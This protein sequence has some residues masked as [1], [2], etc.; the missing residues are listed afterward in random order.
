MPSPEARQFRR[1]LLIV[2]AV[3]LGIVSLRSNH[4][5]PPAS[6]AQD[7]PKQA[8]SKATAE[9]QTDKQ[10]DAPK[11]EVDQWVDLF[12]GK[13]LNGW[14][15]TNFGGEGEVEVDKKKK[16]LIL[17]WGMD[18][19][20]IT[21]RLKVPRNNYEIELECQRV[22]GN[23]FFCGLT[24]PINDSCA[25]LIVGGWGGGVCGISC[26]DRLDA[27]ENETTTYRGFET[28]KWYPVKV[29]VA[30][31]RLEAWVEGKKIVDVSTKKRE[32]YVRAEMELCQ[33]L[34]LASW[35][36]SSAIR[37][38]RMRTLNPTKI[39]YDTKDPADE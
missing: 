20:G 3:V 11:F 30:N 22:D 1:L 33:P 31:D 27:S 38:F 9:K 2:M 24:F 15:K 16:H 19:T 37:K 28:G 39:K 10:K 18:M 34:G 12:D 26:L 21:T 17:N 5:A 13:S 36:T 29:R 14:K 7:E 32:I 6:A 23:D 4:A 25:S 8:A 35:Q